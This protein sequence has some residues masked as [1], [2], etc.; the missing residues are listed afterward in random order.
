MAKF[1]LSDDGKCL[2]NA[3]RIDYFFIEPHDNS[4]A[5][6]E[7]GRDVVAVLRNG[8]KVT[9]SMQDDDGSAAAFLK[10]IG[11]LLK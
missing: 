4:E 10:E 1:I 5:G 8:D 9:I 2:V 6:L 3:D 11:S 7:D